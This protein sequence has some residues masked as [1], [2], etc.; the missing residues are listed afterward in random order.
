MIFTSVKPSIPAPR[1][2]A[3]L[4]VAGL[5]A[6]CAIPPQGVSTQNIADFDAAVASIECRLVT[7]ADYLAVELQTGLPR[8]KVLELAKY[9]L[10]ADQAQSLESGG[11]ALTTGACA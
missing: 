10:A 9:K 5:L 2:F 7:E 4:A 6:A 8:E 3:G 1:V 11:I